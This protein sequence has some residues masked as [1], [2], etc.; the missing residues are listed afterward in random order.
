MASGAKEVQQPCPYQG[1]V[2]V[3][4]INHAALL[5]YK[6]DITSAI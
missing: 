6:Q 4:D 1:V 5:N 3:V 2:L